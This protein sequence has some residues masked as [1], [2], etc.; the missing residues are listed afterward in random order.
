MRYMSMIDCINHKNSKERRRAELM[1][2]MH[3]DIEALWS[4]QMRLRK[5]GA[6]SDILVM[7]SR[8]R[9]Q[10]SMERRNMVA[11]MRGIK[12]DD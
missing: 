1:S 10:I 7:L 8:A 12:R 6:S 4:M 5:T 11:E 3:N 9:E 2:E